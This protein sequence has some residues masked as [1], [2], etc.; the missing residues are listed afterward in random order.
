MHYV[1]EKCKY[2]LLWK[3]VL[4]ITIVNVKD[5]VHTEQVISLVC[6]NLGFVLL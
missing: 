6:M 3:L 1:I 2:C 4:F 5:N